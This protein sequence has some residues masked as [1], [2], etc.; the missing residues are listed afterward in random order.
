MAAFM[1]RMKT[2]AEYHTHNETSVCHLD[3]HQSILNSKN[4][5]CYGF[6]RCRHRARVN[7]KCP[8]ASRHEAY[9]QALSWEACVVAMQQIQ[10]QMMNAKQRIFFREAANCPQC[11]QQRVHICIYICAGIE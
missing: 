8:R 5:P 10:N 11:F 6:Y 3:G 2:S 9:D 7:A 1:H 4:N